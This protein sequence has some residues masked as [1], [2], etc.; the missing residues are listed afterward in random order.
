M[1][2]RELVELIRT[3]LK[4]IS[5]TGTGA[6]F[7]SGQGEQYATPRAFSKGKGD[8]KATNYIKKFGYTKVQRPKRPSHTKLVDYLNEDINR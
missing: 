7:S 5:S 8:N 3:T 6:S 4:E 2:K 1:K